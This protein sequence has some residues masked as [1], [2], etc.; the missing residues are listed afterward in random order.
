M[1]HALALTFLFLCLSPTLSLA[2]E[3]GIDPLGLKSANWNISAMLNP[4]RTSPKPIPF[5]WLDDETFGNR[6]DTWTHA[7]WSNKVGVARIHIA[8]ATCVRNRAC[9]KAE[10]L[11]GYTIQSLESAVA[12]QNPGLFNKLCAKAQALDGLSAQFPHI[13]VFISGMLEHDLSRPSAE[14]VVNLMRRC[15]PRVKGI[16]DS[17][18]KK[19][20]PQIPGSFLECHGTKFQGTCPFV[21]LDGEDALDVDLEAAKQ[22][23]TMY[24]FVWGRPYNC[25]LPKEGVSFPP[26]RK[27]CPNQDQFNHYFRLIYPQP[28]PPPGPKLS[29]KRIYK[30]SSDNHGGCLGKD[31]RPVYI[32]PVRQAQIAIYALNGKRLGHLRYYGPYDGGG[33]RY[34]SGTGSRQTAFEFGQQAEATAGSEFFLL[35]EGKTRFV[36]NAYRRGGIYR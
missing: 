20:Y 8:N 3:V 22:K 33:Y 28:A 7:L 27:N 14:K 10:L 29:G 31:C 36:V 12:S 26:A 35:E 30:P 2:G 9:H 15:A 17:P 5:G 4:L 16:V 1:R 11:Y 21:S 19:V 6:T 25:R 13:Q 34:Y 32:G 24:F 18:V 23:A